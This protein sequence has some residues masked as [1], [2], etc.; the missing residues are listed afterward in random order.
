[1]AHARSSAEATDLPVFADLE[2]GFGDAPEIVAENCSK[3]CSQLM[4]LSSFG[5]A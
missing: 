2:K 4:V 5:L 3:A 1:M